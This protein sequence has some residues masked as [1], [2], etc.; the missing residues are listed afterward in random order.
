MQ[1]GDDEHPPGATRR[2]SV[3]T[4]RDGK[5][6]KAGDVKAEQKYVSWIKDWAGNFM[7]GANLLMDFCAGT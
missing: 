1:N 3:L 4:R 2:G 6:W 5:Q 7:R